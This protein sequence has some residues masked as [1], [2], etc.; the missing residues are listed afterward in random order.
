MKTL[1]ALAVCL[2]LL[3][4]SVASATTYTVDPSTLAGAWY[5][6]GASDTLRMLPGTYVV[7]EPGGWWPLQLSSNS[8]CLVGAGGPEGVVLLGSGDDQA[9][10]LDEYDYAHIHFEHITFRGIGEI[11]GRESSISS[12]GGALHFTDNIVEYCGTGQQVAG[13]RV[14]ECSGLIARNVFRNNYSYAI[15]T[16]HTTAAIED[17]EMYENLGGIWDMCCE[18]PPIRRNHIHDN[19]NHAIRA[20]YWE[21]GPCEYNVIERN[22]GTGIVTSYLGT[23]EH[24]V[25]RENAVG[26]AGS[27]WCGSAAELHYNDICDNDEYNLWVTTSHPLTWDCTHNWWGSIDPEVISQTIWDCNDDPEAE[28]C[29]VFE[30]FCTAAG[31]EPVPVE[32]MSWGGIKALYRR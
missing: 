27:S 22:G 8:P 23:V 24:N 2:A 29:V 12:G 5:S 6:C 20:A 9:F 16:Y 32:S 4:P 13:L 3:L 26:V 15:T 28:T 14:T 30:P 7:G 1:C 17:N 10:F 19:Q 18:G 11:L 25:I 21:S 31:C